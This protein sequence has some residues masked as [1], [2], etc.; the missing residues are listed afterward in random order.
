[1]QQAPKKPPFNQFL[2]YSNLAIQMIAIIVAGTFGGK[3]LDKKLA[4]S[5]PVFTVSLMILS[6]F[7]AVY[8]SIREFLKK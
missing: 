1:V 5:F 3:Y 2:R 7:I 6:V 4:F 8:L